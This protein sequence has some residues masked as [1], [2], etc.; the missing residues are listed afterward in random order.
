MPKLTKK[1]I[2]AI[3][4]PSSGA[5]VLWDSVVPG[6]GVRTSSGGTRTYVLKYRTREERVVRWLSIARVGDLTLDEA[7]DEATK[8]RGDIVK[9]GDPAGKLSAA[10]SA[11]TFGKLCD[12]YLKDCETRPRPLRPNTLASHRSNIENH[13][14]P[15]LG[16]RLAKSIKLP[17]IE[18]VQSEIAT[19]KTAVRKPGRG[20]VTSGGEGAAARCIA[21]LGAIFEYGRRNNDIDANP[22]ADVRKLAPKSRERFLSM[23]EIRRLGV[24]MREAVSDGESPVG[25]SAVRF[26]LLSGFRR[27]EALSLEPSFI[28]RSSQC[29]RLPVTKTGRQTRAIGRAALQALASAPSNAVWVFPAE[30]GDGH[31]VGLP[32]VLAQLF[33]RAEIEAASAHD[34]RRTF[35]TVAVE[36]GF[37]EL[38]IAA[39]LGHK[40]AGVTARYA[41]T[42]D[43]A[44]LLAADAISE[45]IA[46]LLE[47]DAVADVIPIR[48]A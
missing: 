14:R 24:A 16:N 10:R 41:R 7:R 6:F 11:K 43:K 37:S 15:A 44:L 28:D 29:A 42:P 17:D 31:F 36:L 9:G 38:V 23:E 33:A 4:P 35:A 5:E 34:L 26:I 21:V 12:E 39:L 40:T 13:L 45:R 46:A 27:N 19:G 32:K 47:G 25:V 22:V 2:D 30:R 1:L 3:D 8:H 48:R 20:G 18:R